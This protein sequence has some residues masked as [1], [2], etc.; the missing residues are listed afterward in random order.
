MKP[1]TCPCCGY[2]V[3]AGPPGSEELC[4]ICGWRDDLMHLRFVLFN[5]LPNGISLADAQQNFVALG[6]KDAASLAS[7]RFP[8]ATDER[9]TD[10]RPFDSQVDEAESIPTDYVGLSTPDDPTEFY[11]WLPQYRS[12]RFLADA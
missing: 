2:R 7:V 8:T 4:P 11:Y 3:F 5:G 6:A 1:Y 10:W 9:D 12:K